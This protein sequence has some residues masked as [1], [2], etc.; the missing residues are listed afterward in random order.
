MN[1]VIREYLDSDYDS[2]YP[3]LLSVF[4]VQKENVH[5]GRAHEFVCEYDGIVV[6]YFILNEMRDVVQ[7]FLT[8]HVDYVCV[9]SAYQGR[10]IGRKM[11]DFV[12]HYAESHQVKRLELTSRNERVV[13]HQLY[14]SLGFEKRDSSIYRKELV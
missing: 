2:V 5:D 3:L 9:D 10:G 4:H 6:G 12:I 11:M 8:Y 14:S 13:A 7:D 1:I